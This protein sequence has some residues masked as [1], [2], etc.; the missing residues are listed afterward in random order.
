MRREAMR[1]AAGVAHLQRD[2]P[3]AWL[4]FRQIEQCSRNGETV[5][6]ARMQRAGLAYELVLNGKGSWDEFR[7]LCKS[8]E[9][10]PNVSRKTLATARLMRLESF[11]FDK[12]CYDGLAEAEAFCQDY[13]DITRE[14]YVGLVWNG[15][16]LHLL[17]FDERACELLGQV[18]AAEIPAGEKFAGL[19]PGAR[20]AVWLA[21]IA[22]QTGDTA[23]R[24]RCRTVLQERYPDSAEARHAVTMFGTN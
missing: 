23:T 9:N 4:A 3:N 16:Y 17:G 20:A 6:E 12:N 14:Y 11:F 22:D 10:I 21:Y 1:R 13:R 18:M 15:I 2:Y 5:A 19:E 24:D 8:V 7:A